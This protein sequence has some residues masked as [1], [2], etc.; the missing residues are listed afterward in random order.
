MQMSVTKTD[1]RDAVL[2][3]EYGRLIQPPLYQM[4]TDSLLRLRQKRTLLRQYHNRTADAAT[5][6][7]TKFTTLVYDFTRQGCQ[8]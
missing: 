4:A 7:A 3:A 1:P 8:C 5:E 6:N 2:L